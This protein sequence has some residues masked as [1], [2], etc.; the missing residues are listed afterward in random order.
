[1]T[2]K[3]M[4]EWGLP[5][6]QVTVERRRAIQN[7]LD[8]GCPIIRENSTVCLIAA[9]ESILMGEFKTPILAVKFGATLNKL[10]RPVRILKKE[11]DVDWAE[12][13]KARD[14]QTCVLCGV[15]GPKIKEG[16]TKGKQDSLTA[17]HWLKTKARSGMARWSRACGVTVHFAEHIHILHENPCWVDLARI[18][19]HVVAE[20]GETNVQHAI[21]LSQIPATD[22]AVRGFWLERQDFGVTEPALPS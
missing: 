5:F 15:S 20:E 22:K 18:H 12:R 21:A 6:K 17:H 3:F 2:I 9:G 19:A 10:R 11:L 13:V 14:R 7:A 8:G 16:A 1:M 4:Q